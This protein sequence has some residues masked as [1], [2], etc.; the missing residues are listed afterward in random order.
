MYDNDRLHKYFERIKFPSGRETPRNPIGNPTIEVLETLQ[1][2]HLAAV[3]FDS[4]S[5]H[6]SQTRLL[7]LDQDDLFEKI[8]ARRRGGYCMEVNAFFRNVLLGLGYTLISA[9]A[10]VNG[11][12][13][14]NGL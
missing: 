5:L 7:S 10:R 13:G 3:P 11:P 2:F 1:K 9:G 14:Y 4:V 8:V 12:G 6:Y